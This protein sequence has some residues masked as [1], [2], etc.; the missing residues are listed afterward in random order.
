MLFY[1]FNACSKKLPHQ[2]FVNRQT[3]FHN[4]MRFWFKCNYTTAT[5]VA[6]NL[7]WK[8][9][10]RYVGLRCNIF[11]RY[12]ST[13]LS[14]Q[15]V[16][17]GYQSLRDQLP[18][19]RRLCSLRSRLVRSV[20][21]SIL[22]ENFSQAVIPRT[23]R[24]QFHVRFPGRLGHRSEPFENSPSQRTRSSCVPGYR[25][26]ERATVCSIN[27]LHVG[28]APAVTSTRPLAVFGNWVCG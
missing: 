19:L 4:K 20:L 13:F 2:H 22:R 18:V 16:Y 25:S 9:C 24:R 26:R 23:T 7:P 17:F 1:L 10:Q 8:F 15:I 28:P 11:Q 3:K 5:P 6:H 27:H 14:S 21:S 12:I